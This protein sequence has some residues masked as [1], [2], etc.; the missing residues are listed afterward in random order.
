MPAVDCAGH[1]SAWIPKP[2]EVEPA[3]VRILPSVK[4]YHALLVA[5]HAATAAVA[6]YSR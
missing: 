1:A 2:D 6:G 3:H 4:A 5:G